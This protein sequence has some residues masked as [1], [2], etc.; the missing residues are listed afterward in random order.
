MA[1]PSYSSHSS[2]WGAMSACEHRS[3]SRH[4]LHDG[5]L[6][7]EMRTLG[8]TQRWPAMTS[9]AAPLRP[10]SPK[11]GGGGVTPRGQCR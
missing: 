8:R 3:G 1:L 7:F 6:W 11:V 10:V 9:D 5:R 4:T 2:H